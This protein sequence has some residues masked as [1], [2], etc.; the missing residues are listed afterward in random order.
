MDLTEPITRRFDLQ[1]KL[2][3]VALGSRRVMSRQMCPSQ[4]GKAWLLKPPWKITVAKRFVKQGFV[5]TFWAWN[6]D[7]FMTGIRKF[8]G[9][10]IPVFLL[11]RISSPIIQQR[12]AGSRSVTQMKHRSANIAGSICDVRNDTP[13][14]HVTW[15][16]KIKM[17]GL[18]KGDSGF[19]D[20]HVWYLC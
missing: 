7:W 2:V 14:K 20:G 8:H 17:M 10:Y 3:Q 19:K 18:A 11:G 16:P 15:E 5:W 6:P 1:G 9:L 4:K 13:P 12:V